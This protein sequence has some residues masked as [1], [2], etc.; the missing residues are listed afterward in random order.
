MLKRPER[1]MAGSFFSGELVA[2]FK[3]VSWCKKSLM[4]EVQYCVLRLSALPPREPNVSS[5]SKKKTERA[6]EIAS[7]TT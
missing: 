3:Q 6:D 7:V 4:I 1:V 5:S 2:T